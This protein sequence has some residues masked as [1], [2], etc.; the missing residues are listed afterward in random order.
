MPQATKLKAA[1]LL[2]CTESSCI[3]SSMSSNTQIFLDV[4]TGLAMLAAKCMIW[5]SRLLCSTYRRSCGFKYL[6]EVGESC[7]EF[8]S[9]ILK[10]V[11]GTR[12]TAGA[13]PAWLA[14][15]EVVE[16]LCVFVYEIWNS[17][18]CW[19]VHDKRTMCNIISEACC[20]T[21]DWLE[22]Q[23]AAQQ[24]SLLCIDL[25]LRSSVGKRLIGVILE[26]A[27]DPDAL[28]RTTLSRYGASSSRSL[29]TVHKDFGDG[30]PFWNVACP[31]CYQCRYALHSRLLLKN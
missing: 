1:V 27:I 5:L 31:F 6:C 12:Q 9:Y 7:Y 4:P 24:E 25:A 20:L 11:M 22:T 3:E 2:S 23:V 15:A 18:L 29:A 8:R 13:D 10:W 14:W 21:N 16:G 26:F 28:R 30:I 19:D 17:N